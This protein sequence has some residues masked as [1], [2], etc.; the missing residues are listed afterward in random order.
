MCCAR[1]TGNAGCKKIA[2]NSPSGHH[3]TILSGYIFATKVRID[4]RKNVLNSNTSSIG[5][6]NMVNIRP[7]AAEIGPVV[8]GTPAKFNGFPV[9]AALLHGTNDWT[10]QDVTWYSDRPCPR[11]HCASWGHSSSRKGTQLVCGFP[12]YFYFRFG[13]GA[14]WASFFAVFANSCTR[15]SVCGSLVLRLTFNNARSPYFRFC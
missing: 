1:L 8:W 14:S 4:N 13:V 12:P 9:F 2:K 5:T 15:Y 10:D 6:H 11:R 3:R 7:L